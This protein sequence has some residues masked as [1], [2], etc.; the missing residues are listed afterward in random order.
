MQPSLLRSLG[1][2]SCQNAGSTSSCFSPCESTL[3]FFSLEKGSLYH[4]CAHS[5]FQPLRFMLHQFPQ[6]EGLTA[7][8]PWIQ[9]PGKGF[10]LAYPG[11]VV[12]FGPINSVHGSGFNKPSCPGP[13]IEGGLNYQEKSH[14]QLSKYPQV[15]PLYPPNLENGAEQKILENR[16]CC[17]QLVKVCNSQ[18][19]RHL[20][21]WFSTAFQGVNIRSATKGELLSRLFHFRFFLKKKIFYLSLALTSL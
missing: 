20:P 13:T 16:C 19:V 8:A 12:Y 9:I 14:C 5:T 11:P 4:F 15:C 17:T 6:V 21:L 18:S 10:W 7:N 1:W 2:E 3:D